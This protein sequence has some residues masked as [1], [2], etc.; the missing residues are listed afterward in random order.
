MTQLYFRKFSRS[1]CTF[2]SQCVSLPDVV[3]LDWFLRSESGLDCI[4]RLK[5]TTGERH[6]PV[7]AVTANALAGDRETCLNAGADDYLAKP[8]TLEQFTATISR[9]SDWQERSSV[10]A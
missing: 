7:V 3:L 4:A 2:L 10:V 1:A 6:L 9:W 5:E 8:F